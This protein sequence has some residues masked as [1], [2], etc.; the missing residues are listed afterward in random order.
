METYFRN[1]S[2][3]QW[4]RS[5]QKVKKDVSFVWNDIAKAFEIRGKWIAWIPGKGDHI[6][7]DIDPIVGGGAT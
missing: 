2:N 1:L 5:L 6:R 3:K 7:V 4:I